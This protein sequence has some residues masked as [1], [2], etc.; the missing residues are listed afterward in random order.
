[1][2]PNQEHQDL[3]NEARRIAAGLAS[4]EERA[5]TLRDERIISMR[6]LHDVGVSWAEIGRAFDVSPQ[7][8]MYATGHIRRQARRSVKK[9]DGEQ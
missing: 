3:L 8:A 5:A 2:D 7:A 6:K 4:A 9:T 1:M